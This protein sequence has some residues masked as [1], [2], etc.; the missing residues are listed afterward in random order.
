MKR[1]KEQARQQ[2]RREKAERKSH[3]K[4]EKQEGSADEM[5]ELMEHAEAQAALFR[6][7]SDESGPVEES[8]PRSGA[9]ID[10]ETTL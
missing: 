3:R 7:G 1:Q 2:K 6:M 4:Q 8:T 9:G 10:Q 5:R